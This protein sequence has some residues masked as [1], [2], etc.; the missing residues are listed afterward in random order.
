MFSSG[1][2]APSAFSSQL[3]PCPPFRAAAAMKRFSG[4]PEEQ[5]PDHFGHFGG[6]LLHFSI[7]GS[8]ISDRASAYSCSTPERST[9]RCLSESLYASFVAPGSAVSFRFIRRMDAA[10]SVWRSPHSPHRRNQFLHQVLARSRTSQSNHRR[11]F[12]VFAPEKTRCS[13][14]EIRFMT[15]TVR[16]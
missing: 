9:G 7:S 10:S 5:P 15:A 2:E 16:S 12:P 14:I 13:S 6:Q 1:Q 3:R 4:R 8:I 11:V